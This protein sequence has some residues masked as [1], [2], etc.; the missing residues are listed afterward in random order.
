MAVAAARSA[1]ATRLWYRLPAPQKAQSN[2][3]NRY[4]RA[5]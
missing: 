4:N 2:L 1:H 5:D 3:R